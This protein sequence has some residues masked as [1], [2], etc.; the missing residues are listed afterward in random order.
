[1]TPPT[2]Q[3]GTSVTDDVPNLYQT[4]RTGVKKSLNH[5][6]ELVGMEYAIR[7]A[8]DTPLPEVEEALA[9]YL[10]DAGLEVVAET[11]IQAIHHHYDLEYPRYK[12]LKV[13]GAARLD[14]CPLSGPAI[15][16]NKGMTALLPPSV[17]LYETQ[18]ETR[19]SAIRPSTLLALFN[20][21]DVREI[22]QKLEGLLWDTLDEGVPGGRM[23]SDEPPLPPGS[24][25]RARVKKLLYPV[26]KLLDA[27]Y[28]MHVST[29]EPREEVEESLRHALSMRGQKVLGEVG[30]EGVDILLV[31][32]PGQ[33]HKLLAIEP[34]VGVFA[35]LSVGIYEEGDRT[36]VRAVR[37]STLLIFFTNPALQHILLEIEVLLWNSLTGG[38]PGAKIHSR[39]PPL[40]SGLGQATTA[41]GLPGGLDSYRKY[42]PG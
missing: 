1:M 36:H 42:R 40:P 18:G 22:I 16:A 23:L 41:A 20:D 4:I 9:G 39:Q 15:A 35:P 28:S 19:V 26:L 27:E 3:G 17:I 29:S 24:N 5:V 11:D 25:G 8:T 37:P 30:G 10:D 12:I 34:D 38:V 31:A 32:N 14:E 2:T 6:V 13:A 7:A 21:G 33:A